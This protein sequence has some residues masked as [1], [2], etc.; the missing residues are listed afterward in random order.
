MGGRTWTNNLLTY[1]PLRLT[2]QTWSYKARGLQDWVGGQGRNANKERKLSCALPLTH[3]LDSMG[4]FPQRPT[5]PS[6]SPGHSPGGP[7]RPPRPPPPGT[8]GCRR[9]ARTSV[10]SSAPGRGRSRS[11]STSPASPAIHWVVLTRG[12]FLGAAQPIATNWWYMLMG[13]KIGIESN[14]EI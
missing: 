13:G 7:L 5:A 3:A 6:P 9:G 8:R 11:L 14:F 10:G 12:N 2:N 1:P 4:G